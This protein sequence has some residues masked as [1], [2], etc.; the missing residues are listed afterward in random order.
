MNGTVRSWVHYL[1]TRLKDDTQK[2]H[3]E[4]A[5]EIKQIFVGNF[6]IISEVMR[7]K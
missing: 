5:E 7:W 3:R 6:P 4:I 2:E 1:E